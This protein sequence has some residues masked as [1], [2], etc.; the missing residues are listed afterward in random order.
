[1]E[2][3]ELLNR[4][5]V[6]V[7]EAGTAIMATVDQAGCTHMRWMTPAVLKHRPGAIF[8][9]SAPQA[10]KV[11]QIHTTGCAEWMFQTR[12]LRQIINITGP[13]RVLDNPALKSELMEILGPRLVVFWKANL[14]S[15]EF[16]VIETV[17][18]KATFFEPMKGTHRTV[19]FG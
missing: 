15:D 1:M 3:H 5:E 7:D 18:E 6:I 10:P 2:T 12:D 19:H 11:E 14:N 13:A 16:V 4:L 9:F 17:I 8:A